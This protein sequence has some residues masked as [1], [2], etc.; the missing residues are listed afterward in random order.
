QLAGEDE[1]LAPQPAPLRRLGRH[2]L[3][4][5]GEQRVD[6]MLVAR[7]AEE[8]VDALGQ[9]RTDALDLAELVQARAADLLERAE[10]QG[11]VA[12][13][14][15]A[16]TG[17]AQREEEAA[18]LDL[19]RVLDRP[20]EL[21]RGA[22]RE[23]RELRDVLG[24]ELIEIGQLADEPAVPERLCRHLADPADVH[25]I[26]RGVVADPLAE[27]GG[28]AEA[29]GAAGERALPLEL[30]ATRRAVVGEAVR[31]SPLAPGLRGPL[32]DLGDPITSAVDAHEVAGA[33]VPPPELLTVVQR[34]TRDDDTADLY[35]LELRD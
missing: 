25:R 34:C 12:A 1:A 8:R 30:R 33:D 24:A 15:L 5:V 11:E 6:R 27:L 23:V 4:A 17:D 31:P 22:D 16:G 20:H 21:A 14:G 26:P 13:G 19:L 18:Q 9:R 32:H 28:A 35:R 7:L 10:V 2:G 3:D 29:V